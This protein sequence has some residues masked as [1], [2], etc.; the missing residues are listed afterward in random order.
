[1][2]FFLV[3]SKKRSNL[4]SEHVEFARLLLFG[5]TERP[6]LCVEHLIRPQ[7]RMSSTRGPSRNHNEKCLQFATL[8]LPIEN[9]FFCRVKIQNTC[10]RDTGTRYW[11]KIRRRILGD[12]HGKSSRRS[13][14]CYALVFH[15]STKFWNVRLNIVIVGASRGS[16]QRFTLYVL[17]I[18]SK[19]TLF[20]PA[21]LTK[22]VHG[23]WG[24]PEWE[25]ERECGRRKQFPIA[26]NRWRRRGLR[27]TRLY[28]H[29]FSKCTRSEA[30]NRYFMDGKLI[31]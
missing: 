12:L 9:R 21:M 24:V 26:D 7:K 29:P 20:R 2:I 6:E 19:K 25:R 4:L 8:F 22:C 17:N 16:L 3:K 15:P 31:R 23:C 5:W 11:L 28:R 30:G 18:I 27:A 14:S 13:A 10:L 1:M